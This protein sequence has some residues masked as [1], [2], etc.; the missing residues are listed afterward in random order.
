MNYA[1][2]HCKTLLTTGLLFTPQ[3]IQA[4]RLSETEWD[5]KNKLPVSFATLVVPSSDAAPDLIDLRKCL[6]F[7]MNQKQQQ[8]KHTLAQ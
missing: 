4:K 1:R 8:Q 6:C 3:L 5:V 2:C 7:Y